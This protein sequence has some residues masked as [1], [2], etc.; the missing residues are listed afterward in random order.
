MNGPVRVTV[1]PEF[2]ENH[3]ED[4]ELWSPGNPLFPWEGAAESGNIDAS[5]IDLFTAA[6]YR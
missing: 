4:V 6:L 5:Q 3:L 1:S 2:Y